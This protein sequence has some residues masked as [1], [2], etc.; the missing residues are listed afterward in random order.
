MPCAHGWHEHF[1]IV[2]GFWTAYSA[3]HKVN[4]LKRIHTFSQAGPGSTQMPRIAAFR[5]PVF[6]QHSNLFKATI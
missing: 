2:S 3:L 6:P 5:T 1:S 4:A